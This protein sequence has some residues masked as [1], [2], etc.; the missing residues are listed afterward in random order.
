MTKRLL[1]IRGSAA[2]Q[3]NWGDIDILWIE[4]VGD[5][6]YCNYTIHATPWLSV[7]DGPGRVGNHI[8]T[9]PD[10]EYYWNTDSP[11]YRYTHNNTHYLRVVVCT[12]LQ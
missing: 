7:F 2:G 4:P 12:P 9:R 3:P 1:N 10:I 8:R 6:L 11:W 5:L